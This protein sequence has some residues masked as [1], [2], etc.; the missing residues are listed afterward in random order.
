MYKDKD[1]RNGECERNG[2]DKCNDKD[3]SMSNDK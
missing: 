2:K 1:K 3:N